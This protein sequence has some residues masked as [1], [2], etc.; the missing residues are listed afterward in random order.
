[1][2]CLIN[3][4]SSYVTH[5][6]YVCLTYYV[7]L[8]WIQ[9]C[10]SMPLGLYYCRN[11]VM[12][13]ILWLSTL[14]STTRPKVTMGLGTRSCL[15]SYKHVQNGVVT[16]RG[17]HQKSILITSPIKCCILS[18]FFLIIR[19]TGWSGRTCCPCRLCINLGLCIYPSRYVI[20]QTPVR[21]NVSRA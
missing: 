1:M 11:I 18:H 10:V 14:Q 5:L 2:W 19:L 8:S 20:M 12:G 4:G 17:Y 7:V 15:L 9:T 16:L 13:C 3:Y 6:C 21:P